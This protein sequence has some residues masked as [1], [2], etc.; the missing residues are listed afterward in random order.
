MFNFF[1]PSDWSMFEQK[2]AVFHYREGAFRFGLKW[3]SASCWGRREKRYNDIQIILILRI[4]S[5]AL[6]NG[7]EI[8]VLQSARS[9]SLDDHC[10]LWPR[11]ALCLG[12]GHAP[13]KARER[14]AFGSRLELI[15]WKHLTAILNS[16]VRRSRKKDESC[17]CSSYLLSFNRHVVNCTWF[18]TDRF[19][20]RLESALAFSS[21]WLG[22]FCG[23]D[24]AA[25]RGRK[26]QNFHSVTS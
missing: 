6:A 4:T 19:N 1:Y 18:Q 21:A 14:D 23:H 9:N 7:R 15:G 22:L 8:A 12:F 10:S 3:P 2:Q 26:K 13:L 16:D 24:A 5:R 17:P 11:A 20:V 25:H